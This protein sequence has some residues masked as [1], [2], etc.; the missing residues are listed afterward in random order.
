MGFGKRP[1]PYRLLHEHFMHTHYL[2]TTRHDRLENFVVALLQELCIFESS[3]TRRNI[4]IK[5]RQLVAHVLINHLQI[6]LV[7]TA[8]LL[9]KSANEVGTLSYFGR[10]GCQHCS[11]DRDG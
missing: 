8:G 11:G 10:M 5:R 1:M 3:N 9:G 4:H 7:E 6:S 2:S